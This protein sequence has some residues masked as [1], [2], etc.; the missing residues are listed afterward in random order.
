MFHQAKERAVPA[1]GLHGGVAICPIA[2]AA[3]RDRINA[4]VQIG[5]PEGLVET[6][7]DFFGIP[8]NHYVQIDFRGFSEIVDALDGI[9]IYFPNP[10][11]DLRS[12]LFVEEAGCT[13]L[14]ARNALGFVRSR[15]YQE[16]IDGRWRTDGTGDLGR[17]RRQQEFIVRSLDRA[18]D[19]GL[20]NPVTLDALIDGA[21]DAVTVDDTLDG[22]DI[23]DLASQFRRFDPSS[24]DLYELPVASDTVGG[25]SVLRMRSRAAEP[26]LDIF[27]NED[28]NAVSESSIRVQ[29]LNGTGV[30]G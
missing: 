25:A 21:L 28:P 23:I 15:A 12:G 6:I 22:D 5:G 24:L 7:R 1:A 27:R 4:A 13:T 17:V 18:F 2:G 3:G 20:R 16:Q 30:P 11:R 14:D 19:R 10:V 26:V 29:V 9:P 8:I